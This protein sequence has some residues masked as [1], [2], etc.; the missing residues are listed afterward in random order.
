MSIFINPLYVRLPLLDI[1]SE[2]STIQS[3]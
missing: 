3:N 1:V 2:M